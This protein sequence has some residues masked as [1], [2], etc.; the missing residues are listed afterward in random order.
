MS[1]LQREADRVRSALL[2]T[3][4]GAEYDRLYAAQQALVWASDPQGFKSPYDLI[5]GTP[6]GS[7]DCSERNRPPSS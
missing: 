6:A 3:P 5:T 2:V 1:F 4:A 7:E